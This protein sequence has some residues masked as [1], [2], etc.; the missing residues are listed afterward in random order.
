MLFDSITS[1]A[2]AR[3]GSASFMKGPA[4]NKFCET[5]LIFAQKVH[6]QARLSIHLG[7]IELRGIT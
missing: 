3:E 7:L 2:Q 1:S 6:S 4:Y 5:I